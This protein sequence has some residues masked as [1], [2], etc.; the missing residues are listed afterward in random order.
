M[1]NK[2]DTGDLF[3]NGENHRGKASLS[4]FKVT[5]PENQ[6]LSKQTVTSKI[7]EGW[8]VTFMIKHSRYKLYDSLAI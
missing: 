7:Q 6:L 3:T 1:E 4:E 2:F 5:T 8:K